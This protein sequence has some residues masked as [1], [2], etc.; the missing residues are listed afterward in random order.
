MARD[1]MRRA[2]KETGCDGSFIDTHLE[3][4]IILLALLLLIAYSVHNPQWIVYKNP[5]PLA[6]I[7]MSLNGG[8]IP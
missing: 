7:N 1:I 4:I 6:Q 3:A 8:V 5:L 2:K